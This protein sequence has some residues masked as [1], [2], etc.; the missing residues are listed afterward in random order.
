MNAVKE[1]SSKV[2]EL[3]RKFGLLGNRNNGLS[4]NQTSSIFGCF[5]EEKMTKSLGRFSVSSSGQVVLQVL[6][7]LKATEQNS[8]NIKLRGGGM[9]IYDSDRSVS[10]GDNEIFLMSTLS[11]A[12]GEEIEVTLEISPSDVKTNYLTTAT[13]YTWSHTLQVES[14]SKSN[15]SA[16]IVEGK[17]CVSLFA[18]GKIYNYNS[19]A[20][21]EY[22]DF[23]NFTYYGNGILSDCVIFDSGDRLGYCW[24][25]LS[26]ENILYY[27]LSGNIQNESVI[28]EGVTNF[29]CS[30]FGSRTGILVCYIKD[31]LPYYK[32]IENGSVSSAISFE[33]NKSKKYTTISALKSGGGTSYVIVC[34]DSDSN[35]LFE[36]LPEYNYGSSS[37][38]KIS[39]RV[40]ISYP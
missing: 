19:E 32:T 4:V 10:V 28:E 30:A 8:V 24:F 3:E 26:E 12:G 15:I 23:S 20:L 40:S 18:G 39:V 27:S 7:L 34:N 31:G 38:D 16:D 22:L 13:L 6:V 25:R 9:L 36:T 21:P 1:L 14:Q 35:Y 5:V 11:L 33:V 2:Q 37:S 29:S 17:F